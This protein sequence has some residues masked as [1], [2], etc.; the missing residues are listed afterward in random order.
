MGFSRQEYWSG[1]PLPSLIFHYTTSQL[2]Q[3]RLLRWFKQLSSVKITGWLTRTLIP[4]R[5]IKGFISYP[6]IKSTNT[7]EASNS[8][9]LLL[10]FYIVSLPVNYKSLKISWLHLFVLVSVAA[11]GTFS[12]PHSMWD[13]GPWLEIKHGPPALGAWSLSHWTAGN[14]WGN[15]WR[16]VDFKNLILVL[17][18]VSIVLKLLHRQL[19]KD[20]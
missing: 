17:D 4:S 18:Y 3:P 6:L 16:S 2:T 12:L 9:L 8:V 10:A 5:C 15:P 1:V 20:H 7:L 14:S 19:N 13:L 11:R